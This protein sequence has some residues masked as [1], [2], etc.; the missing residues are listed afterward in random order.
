ML[1]NNPAEIS[2]STLT[3]GQVGKAKENID[4]TRGNTRSYTEQSSP[5]KKEGKKRY[6]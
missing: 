6:S 2:A 5:R 3:K 1:I 4:N